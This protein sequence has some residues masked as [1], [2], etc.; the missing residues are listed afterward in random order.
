MDE[1]EKNEKKLTDEQMAQI[2]KAQESASRFC[3]AMR[4]ELY[5]SKA[6]PA[7]SLH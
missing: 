5:S 3:D 6:Y 4:E 1:A 2:R 7:K